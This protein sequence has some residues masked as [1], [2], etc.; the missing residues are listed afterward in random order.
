MIVVNLQRH[1]KRKKE[2]RKRKEKKKVKRREKKKKKLE[3]ASFRNRFR[4]LAIYIHVITIRNSKFLTLPS[5]P[6]WLSG[7]WWCHHFCSRGNGQSGWRKAGFLE[8]TGKRQVRRV[9]T[10]ATWEKTRGSN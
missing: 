5:S 6:S 9:D 1:K 4:S 10:A 3:R 8:E 7:V 2:K